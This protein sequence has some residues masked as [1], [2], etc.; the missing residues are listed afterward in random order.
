M[1]DRKQRL[2]MNEARLKGGFITKQ[3]AMC[4]YGVNTYYCNAQKH[5]GE[6]LTRMVN[7]GM[8]ERLKPGHF[9]ISE[10]RMIKSPTPDP[11]Q[12]ELF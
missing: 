12:K 10:K 4:I 5:V 1:S 6:I 7:N 3:E 8:L 9:K 2:I 11:S